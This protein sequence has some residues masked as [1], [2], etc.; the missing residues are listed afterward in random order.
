MASTAYK[1]PPLIPG[2]LIRRYKRFLAD[3]RLDTGETVTAHCPNSGSMTGC[4][5]PGCPVW[6]SASNNPRRKLKYTWELIKT[7]ASMI[8]INT[9]VPN[10]LVKPLLKPARFRNWPGTARSDLK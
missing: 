10:R 3:V 4:A 9:L 1:L 6:L 5:L 7:P 2:Y 8:G